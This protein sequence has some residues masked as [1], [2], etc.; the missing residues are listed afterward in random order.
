M[1]VFSKRVFKR[2][3]LAVFKRAPAIFQVAKNA[4]VETLLNIYCYDILV[5]F[6]INW[7]QTWKCWPDYPL[8]YWTRNVC[9]WIYYGTKCF[10][11]VFSHCLIEILPQMLNTDCK[12]PKLAFCSE[13]PL[14]YS[15]ERWLNICGRETR[16]IACA[17]VLWMFYPPSLRVGHVTENLWIFEGLEFINIHV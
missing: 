14:F 5:F 7:S 6:A 8:R 12:W 15:F 17:A 1:F 2:H 16:K 4:L 9:S 13:I 11:N 3:Q 10:Y